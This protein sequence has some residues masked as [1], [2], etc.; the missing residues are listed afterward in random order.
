MSAFEVRNLTG[1]AYGPTNGFTSLHD[2]LPAEWRGG[3]N[4]AINGEAAILT[5]WSG[6]RSDVAG[7][8][9]FVHGG[10]HSDSG[11]NGL[12]I[13]DF[14]GST[15]PTGWTIAP[16]S[17]SALNQVVFNNI[18]GDNRPNS[19]HTYDQ[20]HY[21]PALNRLYRF[22]G[23]TWSQNGG[24]DFAYYY[25]L[26][27]NKWSCDLSGSK[28]GTS[29]VSS[30]L[31]GTVI[32]KAD[33]TKLLWMD[34]DYPDGGMFYTSDGTATATEL[35]F[36]RNSNGSGMVAVNIGG[37]NW[38]TLSTEGGAAYV[39]THVINWAGYSV[40]STQ[41]T[42]PSQAAYIY[43][44]QSSA[45]SLVYD[46]ALNCVWIFGLTR[47][48]TTGTLSTQILKLSLADYSVTAYTMT[49]DPILISPAA[50]SAGSYNRHIWFPQWR[51]IGTVQSH[52]APMS[53]IKLPG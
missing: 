49:G 17:L 38:L 13:Y 11:N 12:Y 43:G 39:Y 21:D 2:T 42:H 48:C 44:N 22:G 31:G 4:S 9:L 40:A 10:G 24:S 30:K 7:K 34:G 8:R 36:H 6:G 41:R 35:N 25:D 15:K 19:V 47:H 26:N 3:N 51:V 32:G 20:M 46:V 18:Y 28:F 29:Y 53:I 33:G 50:S 37:D 27:A 14:N 23:T 16:N 45:G 1:S 5:A 52:N